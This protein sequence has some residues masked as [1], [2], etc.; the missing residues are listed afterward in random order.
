MCRSAVPPPEA[1]IGEFLSNESALTAAL[2]YEKVANF[3]MVFNEKSTNLLSFPP[4][5]II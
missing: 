1:I 5:A 3:P 2:C 4:E